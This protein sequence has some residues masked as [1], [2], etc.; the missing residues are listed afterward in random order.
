LYSAVDESE[1]NR[2]VQ[3]NNGIEEDQKLRKLVQMF[4]DTGSQTQ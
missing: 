2:Q 4:K 1:V 3:N